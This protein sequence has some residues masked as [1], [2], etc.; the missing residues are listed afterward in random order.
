MHTFF[1]RWTYFELQFF[2]KTKAKKLKRDFD[3][4]F[5]AQIQTFQDLHSFRHAPFCRHRFCAQ[6]LK[7]SQSLGHGQGKCCKFCDIIRFFVRFF[8]KIFTP[9]N[10]VLIRIDNTLK[11]FYEDHVSLWNKW[12][13]WILV[14]MWIS[15]KTR[16]SLWSKI[17]GIIP[18]YR[19][20]GEHKNL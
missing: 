6:E 7:K 1:T 13:E 20:G 19:I 15:W 17:S 16:Q 5:L 8:F 4:F 3:H 14:F 2:S 11:Y 10:D 9:Q 18:P 12:S